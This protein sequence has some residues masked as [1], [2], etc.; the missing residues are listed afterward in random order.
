MGNRKERNW[1]D[2]EDEEE[3]QELKE[4]EQETEGGKE[5]GWVLRGALSFWG[6][7]VGGVGA[8]LPLPQISW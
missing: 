4:R 8:Q 5:R 1:G 6:E 2:D 7:G 3:W